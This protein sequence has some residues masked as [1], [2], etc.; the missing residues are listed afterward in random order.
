MRRAHLEV[1]AR[2]MEQE[3]RMR[4][5]VARRLSTLCRFYRYCH[6]EVILARNRPP[7]SADPSSTPSPGHRAW[8]ATSSGALLVQAGL[9][10]ARDHA[11]IS[12]LAMNGLRISEALGANVD[13]LDV[14]REHRTLRVTRKG[15]KQTTIPLASRTAR[16][17]D[18]YIGER[19]SG[20]I[21]LGAAGAGW[22][23]TPPTAP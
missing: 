16:A 7:T 6:V 23:A 10:S 9:G 2:T 15:G 21:F 20:P 17:L 14:D 5:I 8:I 1:F 18:L 19:A 11:L 4:S 22:T 12:L 13:N 3:G